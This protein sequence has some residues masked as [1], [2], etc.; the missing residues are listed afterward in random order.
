[1]YKCHEHGED[2]VE[3][4]GFSKKNGNPWKGMFCPVEGC[5]VVEWL[6]VPLEQPIPVTPGEVRAAAGAGD[7]GISTRLD[8]IEDMLQRII[9]SQSL[10]LNVVEGK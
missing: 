10:I 1:M 7:G 4:S 9:K 3:R 8:G 6:P 5:R 2:M